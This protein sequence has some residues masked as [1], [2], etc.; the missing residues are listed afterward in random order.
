MKYES[1]TFGA[2]PSEPASEPQLKPTVFLYPSESLVRERFEY[3]GQVATSTADPIEAWLCDEE[4][5]LDQGFTR[6]EIGRAPMSSEELAAMIKL[7]TPEDE[8]AFAAAQAKF[9]ELAD[10]AEV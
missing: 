7:P 4:Y 3:G 2:G 6:E 10:E 9:A 8:A 1:A 5:L